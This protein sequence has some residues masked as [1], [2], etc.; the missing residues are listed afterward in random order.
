MASMDGILYNWLI[1]QTNFVFGLILGKGF[2]LLF[3]V[4]ILI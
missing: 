2:Y 3:F 4:Q 1:Y